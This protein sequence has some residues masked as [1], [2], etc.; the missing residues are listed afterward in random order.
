[1]TN[2]WQINTRNSYANVYNARAIAVH[3]NV[4]TLTRARIHK[5]TNVLN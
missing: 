5:Q 3:L 1:M 4:C 2:K